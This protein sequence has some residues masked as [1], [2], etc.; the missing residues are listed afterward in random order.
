MILLNLNGTE[1]QTKEQVSTYRVHVPSQLKQQSDGLSRC[2]PHVD[3][4]ILQQ[5]G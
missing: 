1:P 5:P 4:I 2:Y 3:V